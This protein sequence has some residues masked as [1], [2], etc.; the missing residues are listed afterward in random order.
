MTEVQNMTKKPNFAE[1]FG[2]GPDAYICEGYFDGKRVDSPEPGPNQHP[3]Y[4]HGFVNGRDDA[5]IRRHGQT[6][7]QRRMALAQI[8]LVEMRQ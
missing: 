6:A 2:D 5:N 4:V 1:I 7:H 8:L 3:L